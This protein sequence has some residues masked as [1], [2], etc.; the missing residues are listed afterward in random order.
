MRVLSQGWRYMAIITAATQPVPSHW[1][2]L[3]DGEDPRWFDE[4]ATATVPGP[5]GAP[6]RVYVHPAAAPVGSRVIQA[7]RDD[8]AALLEDPAVMQADLERAQH[9]VVAAVVRWAR[10]A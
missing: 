7:A 3:R 8:L 6:A 10:A 5:E 4:R 9:A 1:R 2:A